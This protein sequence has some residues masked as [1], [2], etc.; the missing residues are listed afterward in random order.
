MK[1]I[2]FFSM[3]LMSMGIFADHHSGD[4][5]GSAHH[6]GT[7][8][9][10]HDGDFIEFSLSFDAECYAERANSWNYVATNVTTFLDWLNQERANQAEFIEYVVEPINVWRRDAN[11]FGD[12][13]CSGTYF[14]SQHVKLVLNKPEAA[15]ALYAD[16]IQA[17]Y[18]RLQEAIWPLSLNNG[19]ELPS[20]VSTTIT[21]IE[22]GIYEE[23]A[24]DLRI[25]AKAIAQTKA[26]K[27][28][29]SFLGDGYDGTW[30]LESVDF[31][32]RDYSG[33]YKESV[34]SVAAA[35]MPPGGSPAPALL[36]LK[37]LKLSVTGNFLFR[38]EI[39]LGNDD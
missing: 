30:Y 37:P 13:A 35:P 19:G 26:T 21:G 12:D 2:A 31:R 22:K 11:N 29:L 38:F 20:S 9:V 24:D 14:A 3:L 5:F 18:G 39:Q 34:D 17:F 10:Y 16:S 25:N 23:T 32:E 4:R 27:D 15:S 1:R 28:F 6:S 7:G 8:K 33:Y 36:K